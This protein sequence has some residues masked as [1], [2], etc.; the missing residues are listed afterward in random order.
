VA[1]VGAKIIDAEFGRVLLAEGLGIQFPDD[2]TARMAA[3]AA[4]ELDAMGSRLDAAAN[5][6]E[7]T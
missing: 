1:M 7:I 5:G 2:L 6:G 4:T 3:A